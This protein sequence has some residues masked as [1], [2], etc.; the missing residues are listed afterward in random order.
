M[1]SRG[2]LLQRVGTRYLPIYLSS[3]L[4]SSALVPRGVH[5]AIQREKGACS[6]LLPFFCLANENDHPRDTCSRGRINPGT[7]AVT[8]HR[9]GTAPLAFLPS[10]FRDGISCSRLFCSRLLETLLERFSP[11]RSFP[12]ENCSRRERKIKEKLPGIRDYEIRTRRHLRGMDAHLSSAGQ[13]RGISSRRLPS[14]QRM[15]ESNFDLFFEFSIRTECDLTDGTGRRTAVLLL[16]SSWIELRKNALEGRDAAT[17]RRR[18]AVRNA[19]RS[20]NTLR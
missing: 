18:D 7:S 5:K 19:D 1:C 10:S 12:R 20:K 17:P 9:D 6:C 15:P 2:P 16:R 4:S 11:T 13:A 3:K 8:L 14:S